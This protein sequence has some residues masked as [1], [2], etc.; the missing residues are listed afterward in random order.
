[1]NR[2]AATLG[3][4]HYSSS[5]NAWVGYTAYVQ[6]LIIRC[7]ARHVLE[8]GGGANPA[9]PLDFL[10]QHAVEYTVLDISETEL[11]KAPAGYHKVCGDIGSTQ[12]SFEGIE[13]RHDLVFSK[14]L[15]EHV[16][17]GEQMHRN[18]FRLLA[19]GGKAIHYFPT[20]Y[21]PPFVA[22]LLM[23]EPLA[24]RLLQWLE[25]GREK[26]G[27]K[28]KFPAYYSWCRGPTQRQLARL[29]SLGY[30]V[31]EYIGFFG[32]H[33]YYRRIPGVRRMHQWLSSWLVEHPVA[34]LTSA[35]YVVLSKPVETITMI[36]A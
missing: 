20:L 15:A 9:I 36:E 23:P 24:D 18:V 34:A 11:A 1:M 32:H 35:S 17:N 22:N 14:M 30:V 29:Q 2:S 6:D 4:V 28:G 10:Q 26:E 27:K 12:L 7:G 33:A 8:L 19:P 25:P 16:K 13:G 21:A 5:R 3:H 31:D